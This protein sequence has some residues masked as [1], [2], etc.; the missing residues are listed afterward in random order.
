MALRAATHR[1][2]T[3]QLGA[4]AGRSAAPQNAPA[5]AA[6]LGRSAGLLRVPSLACPAADNPVTEPD[7][8]TTHA[9]RCLPVTT[10]RALRRAQTR[11][12]PVSGVPTLAVPRVL[13]P[14]VWTVR[15][16]RGAASNGTVGRSISVLTAS[17]GTRSRLD[18]LR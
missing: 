5:R 14:L 4:V 7:A 17:A 2:A 18:R 10:G 1:P 15:A 12:L 16:V 11:K 6:T 8:A 9:L 13:V 3:P